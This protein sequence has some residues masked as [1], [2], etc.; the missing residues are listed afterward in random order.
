[1]SPESQ[2]MGT[3]KELIEIVGKI[4]LGT[5]ALCYGLGFVIVNVHYGS[6][7][8]YSA[9]LFRL[10]Y[11]VAGVWALIPVVLML[12]A[13]SVVISTVSSLVRISKRRRKAQGDAIEEPNR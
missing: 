10:N 2:K 8:F 9:G 3:V 1:M 6:Y 12:V 7:G 4:V 11:I 5:L 13:V